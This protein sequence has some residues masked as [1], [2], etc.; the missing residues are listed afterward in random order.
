[1]FLDYNRYDLKPG[2]IGPLELEFNKE[3]VNGIYW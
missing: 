1:M 2:K 3:S